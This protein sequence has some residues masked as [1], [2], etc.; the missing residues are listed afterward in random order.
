MFTK[1][2]K[3]NKLKTVL[4]LI[5]IFL[6]FIVLCIP[7][8]LTEI[9]VLFSLY[10]GRINSGY[11][12]FIPTLPHIPIL[13][14][15][16]KEIQPFG[17][18]QLVDILIIIYFIYISIN[19][20]GYALYSYIKLAFFDREDQLFSQ[21][22]LC[23]LRFDEKLGKSSQDQ[24]EIF[25]LKEEFRYCL[26]KKL[27]DVI[28]RNERLDKKTHSSYDD[29]R[30]RGER[31]HLFQNRMSP[32]KLNSIFYSSFKNFKCPISTL[33]FEYFRY[34]TNIIFQREGKNDK[35]FFYEKRD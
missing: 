24:D 13:L 1:L 33:F 16:P 10:N 35:R 31:S 18:G 4:I 22:N 15:F 29:L 3:L 12:V 14:F 17:F 27:I 25:E 7:M 19:I 20:I 2:L 34:F 8:L 11:S 23:Y 5:S 6:F 28:E 26:G 30:K 21:T 9:P 32:P